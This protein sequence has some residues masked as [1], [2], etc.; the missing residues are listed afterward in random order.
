MGSRAHLTLWLVMGPSSAVRTCSSLKSLIV[1]GVMPSMEEKR[2]EAD[3]LAIAHISPEKRISST[4]LVACQA[5]LDPD[6]VAT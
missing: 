4:V 6:A 5:E 2:M 1:E 3:A